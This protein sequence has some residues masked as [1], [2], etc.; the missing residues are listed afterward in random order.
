MSLKPDVFGPANYGDNLDANTTTDIDKFLD[1]QKGN[2]GN[3]QINKNPQ[4]DENAQRYENTQIDEKKI[5]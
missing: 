3:L 1:K 4:I 5:I 2:Y